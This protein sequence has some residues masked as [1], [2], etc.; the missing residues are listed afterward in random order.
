MSKA[1]T[2]RLYKQAKYQKARQQE[3]EERRDKGEFDKC[4]FQPNINSRRRSLDANSQNNSVNG[5]SRSRSDVGM[6]RS[7]VLYENFHRLEDRKRKLKEDEEYRI[8]YE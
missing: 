7:M 2:A 3:I 1:A 8:K 5:R 4:P 6:T